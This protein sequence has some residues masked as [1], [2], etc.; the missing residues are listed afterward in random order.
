MVLKEAERLLSVGACMRTHKRLKMKTHRTT[1]GN[2]QKMAHN[3][4]G[5]AKTRDNRAQGLFLVTPPFVRISI[6]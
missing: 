5:G 3:F 2:Q 4:T 1:T 6:L